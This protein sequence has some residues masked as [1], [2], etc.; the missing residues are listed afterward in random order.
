MPEH[1]YLTKMGENELTQCMLDKGFDLEKFHWET[2]WRS[3]GLFQKEFDSLQYFE[4]DYCFEIAGDD[5]YGI[6]YRPAGNQK[7]VYREMQSWAEVVGRFKEWLDFLEI[8]IQ[9]SLWDKYLQRKK[10]LAIQPLDEFQDESIPYDEVKRIEERFDY[11]IGEMNRRYRLS[12]EQNAKARG[13]KDYL[14]G[15]AK[16]LKRIDWTNVFIMKM[17]DLAWD[18]VTDPDNIAEFG[19]LLTE[20]FGDFVAMLSP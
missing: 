19:K 11:L 15:A 14:V 20:V 3:I 16:R 6:F 4:S 9:P 2:R 10:N 13:V 5:T 12:D 8:E 18:V 1:L 17:L 7:N